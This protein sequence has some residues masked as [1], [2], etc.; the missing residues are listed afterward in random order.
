M[1][2]LSSWFPRNRNQ[3]SWFLG[4]L[5]T[6]EFPANVSGLVGGYCEDIHVQY[7]TILV[8]VDAFLEPLLKKIGS[9]TRHYSMFV[10]KLEITW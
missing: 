7:H 8:I 1:Q 6:S 10:V 5:G 2:L 3:N 9:R 4:K